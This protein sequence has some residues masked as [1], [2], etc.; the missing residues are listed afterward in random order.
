M[1]IPSRTCPDRVGRNRALG[2]IAEA[3]R[4]SPRGHVTELSCDLFVVSE[5]LARISVAA[6]KW[7]EI[8]RLGLG[9]G[10]ASERNV[11]VPM[12]PFKGSPAEP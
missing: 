6:R 7:L 10:E 4:Q 11:D 8:W 5:K 1:P 9:F 2:H 3:V 12:A